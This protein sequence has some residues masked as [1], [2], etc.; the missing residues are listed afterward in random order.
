[1]SEPGP[2]RRR[3]QG[4]ERRTEIVPVRFSPREKAAVAAHAQAA[5]LSLSAYIAQ[6]ALR[7]GGD[8]EQLPL[9]LVGLSEDAQRLQVLLGLGAELRRAAGGDGE[10]AAVAR[11]IDAVLL[12]FR[13]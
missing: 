5:G 2:E 10:V 4:A 12:E 3:R 9:E 1:M 11:R 13:R 6:V 8:P 7:G